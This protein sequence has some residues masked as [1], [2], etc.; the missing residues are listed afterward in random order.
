[1]KAYDLIKASAKDKN[2]RV[3]SSKHPDAVRFCALGAI[4]KCYPE[5]DGLMAYRKL[6]AKI[7]Y[8]VATWNDSVD[9]SDVVA[10]LKGLDI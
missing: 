4:E 7:D 6:A 2:G 1:M 9:H 10:V 5:D 3:I 8:S